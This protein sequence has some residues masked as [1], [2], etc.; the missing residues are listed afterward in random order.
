MNQITKKVQVLKKGVGILMT[1]AMLIEMQPAGQHANA[2]QKLKLNKTK[3]TIT[4]GKTKTLKVTNTNKKVKWEI[5]SG[6]KKISLKNRKKSSVTIKAVKIGS[7]KVQAKAGRKKAVCKVTVQKAKKPA[8]PKPVTTPTVQPPAPTVSAQPTATP[9]ASVVPAKTPA[10]TVSP[11]VEEITD[12]KISEETLALHEGESSILNAFITPGGTGSENLIWKS[13]N[14]SVVAVNG[15]GKVSA[16]AVGMATITVQCGTK[17]ADCIVEVNAA[18]LDITPT[19]IDIKVE[20]AGEYSNWDGVSNVAQFIDGNGEYRFAYDTEKYVYVIKTKDGLADESVCIE[21]RHGTFGGMACDTEGNYYLVTGEANTGDDTAQDTIFVSKYN[22]K[23]D[24]IKEVGDNGS[25]SLASYYDS[26]FYTKEPFHAGNCDVAVNGNIL[27]VHYAREMYSG[28][29]SNSVFTVNTESL[30]KVNVGAIYQSHC[31]AQRAIPY[32]NGFIFAGEGD[33]YNRAFTITDAINHKIT[34]NDIFHFW[35]KENTLNN[36]DMYTLNNNFAHMGG[37]AVAGD[38]NVALVGTS[39]KA[40]TSD[41]EN[42]N[43][44]L[45]VQIFDPAKDLS[46]ESSYITTG[47]RAGIGGPNGNE[48]V[49]DFGVKWLSDFGGNIQISHPQV[50]SGK[51]GTIIILFEKYEDN[52]YKGI[53]YMQ[54][55]KDGTIQNDIT[56]LSGN[57]YLN[58]GRMPVYS[59]GKIYWT[60]NKHTDKEKIYIVTVDI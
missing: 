24:F 56:C 50:V 28:H 27:T 1:V 46:S 47:I 13:S 57:M 59:D 37:L 60:A 44:Q 48:E 6:T 11:A 54:L 41:A 30:E 23:G 53:Y 10:P 43:E 3:L 14:E 45:F 22:E 5:I 33:C 18:G 2:A 25:S 15:D 32:Q 26:S 36:W 34:K 38:T 49:T 21:K 16:K 7:A 35:V 51:N 55:D 40:L 31:F 9:E 20:A 4:K 19:D 39:V 58:P 8:T 42:Q 29:Q 52:D 17:K 12:I